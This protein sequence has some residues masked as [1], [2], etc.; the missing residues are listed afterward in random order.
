M[1]DPAFTEE[2]P[3]LS[4]SCGLAAG[5]RFISSHL[6]STVIMSSESCSI[7]ATA[8]DVINDVH[9]PS[10]V[11]EDESTGGGSG[12]DANFLVTFMVTFEFNWSFSV[13]SGTG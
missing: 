11:V 12:G 2:S 9:P 3:T 4:E 1:N 6:S 13:V 8:D 10:R 5:G 7:Q